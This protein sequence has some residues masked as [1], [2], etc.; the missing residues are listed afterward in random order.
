MSTVKKSKNKCYEL[1][2]TE[3]EMKSLYVVCDNIKGSK[4][5]TRRMH[6]EN[7]KK[8]ILQYIEPYTESVNGSLEFVKLYKYDVI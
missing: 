4:V 2:V 7:L 6:T 1:I 8:C 3:E 5:Y